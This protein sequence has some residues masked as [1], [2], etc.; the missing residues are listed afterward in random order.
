MNR[1]QTSPIGVEYLDLEEH[2]FDHYHGMGDAIAYFT[3][4]DTIERVVAEKLG[5]KLEEA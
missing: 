1:I 2:E 3:A 4:D 5:Q